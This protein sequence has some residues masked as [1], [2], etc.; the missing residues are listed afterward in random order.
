MGASNERQ[1]EAYTGHRPISLKIANK[2][3]ESICKITVKKN[4]G[5]SYGTGFFMNYSDSLK[6]LMTNYHVINPGVEKENIEIE[7]HNNKKMKL[8]F[9]N[10]KTKYLKRPEDIAMIEIKESDEIYKYISFLDYDLNCTKSRYSK[11]KG[12][13]VFSIEHPYGEDASSASGTIVEVYENTFDHNISTDSGSSGCPIILLTNNINLLQVIGIHKEGDKIHNINGGTFIGEIFDKDL[14][15]KN[16]NKEKNKNYI[17]AEIFIKR[18]NV[19]KNIRIINS[20]EE[21]HRSDIDMKI[22]DELK[23][24]DE[25]KKCE[26]KIN[27]ELISFNYFYKFK[28]KGKKYNTIFI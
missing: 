28:S 24:E 17:I 26:I 22:Q 5:T 1:T 16:V 19:N 23:N 20:Y 25:I 9:E 27:N 8:K 2:V 7:I 14:L 3:L 15:I 12:Q 6:C 11:Y 21:F 4:G 13:D 18:E 10:R